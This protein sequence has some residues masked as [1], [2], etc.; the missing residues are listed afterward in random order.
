MQPV[1]ATPQAPSSQVVALSVILPVGSALVS[2]VSEAPAVTAAWWD[3]GDFMNMAVVHVP[4]QGTV[5]LTLVTV[6][7]GETRD[8][9]ICTV[10]ANT[11]LN[12]V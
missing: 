4:V 7:Q 12:G 8:L 1:P 6:F 5:T 11:K 10:I 2:L 3:T 9:S